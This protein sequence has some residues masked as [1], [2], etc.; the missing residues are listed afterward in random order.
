VRAALTLLAGAGGVPRPPPGIVIGMLGRRD[1]RVTMIQN[2]TGRRTSANHP[3]KSSNVR[4]IDGV[5][6][7]ACT[8]NS[9]R[10]E[11]RMRINARPVAALGLVTLVSLVSAA[12]AR[13]AN[14]GVRVGLYTEP[15][16]SFVGGELLFRLSH[17]V[18]LNPNVEYIFRDGETFMTFNGDFHYD[19]HTHGPYVWV[20]AGLAV[21]YHDPDGPAEGNTDVGANILLGVGARGRV[22]P[23]IQAKLIVKEDT[24]FV[25]AA[26]IRF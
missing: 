22:I 9:V 26:G 16:D 17:Q 25:I 4:K 12:P 14:V 6:H 3:A 10:K 19:F 24:Q 8:A 5:R 2:V 1:E 7:A 13:A 23:Y 21:I 20:G 11:G 18:F 15:T